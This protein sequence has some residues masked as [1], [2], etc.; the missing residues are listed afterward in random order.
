[1]LVLAMMVGCTD[2]GGCDT[3]GEEVTAHNYEELDCPIYAGFDIEGNAFDVLADADLTGAENLCV[4]LVD[5]TPVVDETGPLEYLFED[6]PVADDGT[7]AI[8]KVATTSIIG[9]VMITDDCD[10]STDNW[11]PLGTGVPSDVVGEM[12]YG[13]VTTG[14]DAYVMSTANLAVIETDLATAGYS[15]GSGLTTD[16]YVMGVVI[17]GT[18]PATANNMSGETVTFTQD[19]TLEVFYGDS[20]LSDG[21]FTTASKPNT[22][23]DASTNVGFFIPAGPI[24]NYTADY[25]TDR[26][27]EVLGGSTEGIG[28]FVR[29]ALYE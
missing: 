25:G 2:K 26:F 3:G 27:Y 24:G 15:G 28:M 23:T 5:P 8:R 29:A 21:R 9:L 14:H 22:V 4:D 7:F 6:I 17:D 12:D 16:G 11:A 18:D 10:S 1:M 20:D 13:D 19:E